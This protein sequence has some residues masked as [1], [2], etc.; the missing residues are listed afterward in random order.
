MEK[1]IFFASDLHLGAP[2]LAD[3]HERERR[4]VRW[5]REVAPDAGEIHLV[6]DIFDFWMEYRLAVPKGFVRLFGT[7][8]EVADNGVPIV[9]YSGNHDFWFGDYLPTELGVQVTQQPLTRTWFGKTCY[10]AHGD[11]LGPR[12]KTSRA[13]KALLTN[14]TLEEIYKWLPSRMAIGLAH[15]LSATSRKKSRGEALE[16]LGDKEHLWEFAKTFVQHQPD[17][18]YL[19]FGH[20]H[21]MMRR[22]V[23]ERTE[24]VWLGD[25]LSYN[26]YAVL[27]P[28]GQ[29][30]LKQY[31]A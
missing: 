29:L 8:A 10:L 28:D 20:R 11:S 13:M 17:Y 16:D 25:W 4:F 5:L 18:D 24:V 19:I 6:G 22:H 21:L 30:H 3:S 2:T 1:P 12:E 7:L 27:Q 14:S 23:T 31:V 15:F 9:L 26:S